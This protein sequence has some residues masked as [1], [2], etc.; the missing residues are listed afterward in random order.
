VRPITF[1]IA[2]AIAPAVGTCG[3]SPTPFVPR[4]P[5]ESYSIQSTSISGASEHVSNL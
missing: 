1:E 4:G 5:T 3:G 2:F